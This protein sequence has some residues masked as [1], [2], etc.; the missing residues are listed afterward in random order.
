MRLLSLV[1]AYLVSEE[2]CPQR[3]T[4]PL[5]SNDQ[6]TSKRFSVLRASD[7]ELLMTRV[8]LLTFMQVSPGTEAGRACNAGS[9]R[10]SKAHAQAGRQAAQSMRQAR[11]PCLRS[12]RLGGEDYGCR[13]YYAVSQQQQ[14]TPLTATGGDADEHGRPLIFFFVLH[15]QRTV[16]LTP[17][18]RCEGLWEKQSRRA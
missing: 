6:T 17:S 5:P 12:G 3:S 11:C 10:V 1:P 9:L 13:T 2:H 18:I 7:P 4:P 16:E 8:L 15:R 14:P